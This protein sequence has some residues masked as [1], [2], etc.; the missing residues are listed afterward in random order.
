M[1]KINKRAIAKTLENMGK[2][3]KDDQTILTAD[4]KS[5]DVLS[6]NKHPVVVGVKEELKA[7]GVKDSEHLRKLGFIPAFMI[8]KF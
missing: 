4:K 2:R 1:P 8:L 6:L 3:I 5:L 7:L